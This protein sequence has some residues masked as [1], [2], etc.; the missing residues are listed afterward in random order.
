ME[1]QRVHQGS[2]VI[3]R[4][5]MHHHPAGLH[6]HRQVFILIENLQRNVLGFRFGRL[7]LRQ[8]DD[9]ANAG[10]GFV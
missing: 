2:V 4:R 3:A 10:F 6:H 1:E 8:S 5:R 7:D 9:D